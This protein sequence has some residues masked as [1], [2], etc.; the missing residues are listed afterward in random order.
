MAPFLWASFLAAIA[1]FVD[2]ICFLRLGQAF[3]ANMTGNLVEAGVSAA[4]GHWRRAGFCAAILA[5]FLAGA[6]AARLLRRTQ[7]L[8]RLPLA[9]EAAAMVLA[10]SGWLGIGAVPWLA[11]AMALQNAAVTHGMVSV[12]VVFVTGD[13]QQLGEGLADVSPA[14]R[15]A[16]R[17]SPLIVAVL[18][19]YAVGAGI[20]ALA[21]PLGTIALLCPA[22]ILAGSVVLPARWFG[23]PQRPG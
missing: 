2:A 23:L 14:Q 21:A 6:V 15:R 3:A 17:R 13:I 22:A 12:N 19:C 4:G 7:G 5:S 20:G 1:G 11:A 8:P 18:V 10:A 9:I 16:D